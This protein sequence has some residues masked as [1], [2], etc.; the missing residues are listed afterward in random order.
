MDTKEKTK[1]SIMNFQT[2][3]PPFLFLSGDDT[4]SNISKSLTANEEFTIFNINLY[5]SFFEFGDISRM[6]RDREIDIYIEEIDTRFKK[7]WDT[8]ADL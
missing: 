2:K 1:G 3:Y 4:S 6:G 7:A 5:N 8:L